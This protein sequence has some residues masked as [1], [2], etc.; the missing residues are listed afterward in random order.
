MSNSEVLQQLERSYRHPKPLGCPADMYDIMLTCWRSQP[1][2]R[3][4]FD[5]LFHTMD[6]FTV[7]TQSGYAETNPD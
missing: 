2:D 5:H 3:P 7:A 1:H 4:T 6:D